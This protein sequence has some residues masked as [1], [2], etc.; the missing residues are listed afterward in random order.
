M[1]IEL[2]KDPRSVE[3]A[4]HEVITYLETTSYSQYDDQVSG[5]NK[6]VVR[7]V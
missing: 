2:T 3:E 5:R 1:H 7:Q 4:V 6:Q